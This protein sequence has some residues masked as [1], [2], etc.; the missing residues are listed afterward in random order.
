[1]PDVLGEIKEAA[2]IALV[3]EVLKIGLNGV[4]HVVRESL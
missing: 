3:S 4:A 2:G 1:L